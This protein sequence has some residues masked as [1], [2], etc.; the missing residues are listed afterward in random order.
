V[1]PYLGNFDFVGK[2]VLDVGAASGFLTF[3]MEKRGAEVVAQ[4][5]ISCLMFWL[6]IGWT[7]LLRAAPRGI[8]G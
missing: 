8:G 2:R 5:G 6:A 3:E 1:D 4:T 7:R